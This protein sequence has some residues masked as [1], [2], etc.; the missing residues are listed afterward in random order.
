VTVGTVETQ[1][2]QDRLSVGGKDDLTDSQE[3]LSPRHI[4]K[5]CRT[6]VRRRC[7]HLFIRVSDF[8]LVITLED[9]E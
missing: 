1:H 6:R 5:I 2:V 7:I 8:N 3:R 9:A 4:E